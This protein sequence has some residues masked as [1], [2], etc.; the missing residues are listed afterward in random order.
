MNDLKSKN[1]AVRKAFA[2]RL[3]VACERSP[4]CPTELVR[5][6]QKWLYETLEAR[7]DTSVSPEATRKWFA[8]ETM[9][10]QSITKQIAEILSVDFAWLAVGVESEMSER[11]KRQ[12]DAKAS[13]AMNYVAGII[14]SNG[15][16]VSF[17]KDAS[18]EITAIIEGSLYSLEVRNPLVV[19]EN[20]LRLTTN[21]S[22]I[23]LLCVVSGQ[24]F[25]SM[26]VIS[27]PRKLIATHGVDQG[28]FCEVEI[29]RNGSQYTIG[30][31]P[32]MPLLNLNDLT[33]L[34]DSV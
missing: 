23:P 13:G 20:L 25:S 3:N 16:G 11:Q 24:A 31:T 28:G 7:F 2:Q 1:A 10:R 17:P 22:E 4:Q 18:H 14:Q 29:K 6:K 8:G 5:G 26:A 30:D 32:L 33:T 12:H 9:P 27:I 34:P 19:S 15:G 21:V